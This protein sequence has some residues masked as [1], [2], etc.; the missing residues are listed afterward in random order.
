MNLP[1]SRPTT[2]FRNTEFSLWKNVGI[3]CAA[4]LAVVAAHA[5]D[6]ATTAPAASTTPA[7]TTAPAATSA[8]VT[9][10]DSTAGASAAASVVAPRADL[11]A[12]LGYLRVHS[13]A[14]ALE[15]TARTLAQGTALVLDLRGATAT[16][17]SASDLSAL[18]ARR[19]GPAPLFILVSPRT[20]PE[21]T[22][23]LLRPIPH[24]VLLGVAEA[25]PTPQIVVTQPADADERAYEALDRGVALDALITGKIEKER[26]D[27]AELV[28]EF[29][30]GNPNAAPPPEP[31]PTKPAPEKAPV[32]TDRVLQR[33][34]QLHRALVAL[35][36][37]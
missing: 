22:A 14:A 31:D 21:L 23:P 19:N 2:S 6:V 33:A 12:G 25:L 8:P 9:S 37:G 30:N 24:V 1:V 29:Q 32:L 18:F 7:A 4:L 17:A 5:D 26:F 28:K 20:A 15:E 13:L 3:I 27:E 10:A 34:V 11:G 35:Q 36:R 16:D